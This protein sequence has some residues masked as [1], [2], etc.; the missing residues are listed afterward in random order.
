MSKRPKLKD[1][2]N[3]WFLD[4][5]IGL[6]QNYRD[7]DTSSHNWS[8]DYIGSPF[9]KYCTNHNVQGVL[10]KIRYE[11]FSEILQQSLNRIQHAYICVIFRMQPLTNEWRKIMLFKQKHPHVTLVIEFYMGGED[12]RYDSGYVISSYIHLD[13]VFEFY[14]YYYAPINAYH[15]DHMRNIPKV[16]VAIHY[17][18]QNYH[19]ALSTIQEYAPDIRKHSLECTFEERKEMKTYLLDLIIPELANMIFEYLYTCQH[20]F[21]R[22]CASLEC[23][24]CHSLFS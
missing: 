19:Y 16:P 2:T 4:Q 10:Y 6:V 3:P 17:Q 23:Y 12:D 1:N 24:Q 21:C 15:R 5:C 22:Y 18:N 20:S 7:D 8:N 9:L 13:W 14:R 11:L